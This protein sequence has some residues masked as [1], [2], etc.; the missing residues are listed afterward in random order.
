MLCTGR[1]EALN[2]RRNTT[3]RRYFDSIRL[4]SHVAGEGPLLGIR[5]VSVCFILSALFLPQSWMH[6]TQLNRGRYRID[7]ETAGDGSGL[8]HYGLPHHQVQERRT[9]SGVFWCCSSASL[10][11]VV[12]FSL[13]S[14]DIFRAGLCTFRD[15]PVGYLSAF[16]AYFDSD[17]SLIVSDGKTSDCLRGVVQANADRNRLGPNRMRSAP[18]RPRER[19]STSPAPPRGTWSLL[20]AH[21][22]SLP[23]TTCPTSSGFRA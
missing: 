23:T 20:R 8:L 5:T 19:A 15:T 16:I 18:L 10:T 9:V 14:V 17:L 12:V 4:L 6:R 3:R 2:R 7:W 21:G 22:G 13:P 1:R 11:A